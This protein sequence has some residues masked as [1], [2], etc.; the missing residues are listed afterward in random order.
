MRKGY[1]TKICQVENGLVLKIGC[2]ILVAEIDELP[3][4]LEYYK[5][6]VPGGYKKMFKGV[7]THRSEGPE[8][9]ATT[10]EPEKP[11]LPS[12]LENTLPDV[13]VFV[14]K[15]GW[16]INKGSLNYIAKTPKQLHDIILNAPEE[17]NGTLT[18][19]ATDRRGGILSNNATFNIAYTDDTDVCGDSNG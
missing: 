8:A 13:R 9:A 15:N 7:K 10:Y 2:Q 17:E 6:K 1:D 19:H 18:I 16:L 11:E 12:I 3:K 5:G 14:V 4:L